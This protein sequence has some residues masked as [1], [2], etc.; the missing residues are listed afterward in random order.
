VDA[1]DVNR[2]TVRIKGFAV[3][4]HLCFDDFANRGV[5]RLDVV[6]HPLAVER[7]RGL[8]N[9]LHT[10]RDDAR[11]NLHLAHGGDERKRLAGAGG[12]GS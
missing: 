4:R 1:S 8:R 6:G 5:G 2:G 3:H 11:R 9:Q 10:V 7:K 12:E